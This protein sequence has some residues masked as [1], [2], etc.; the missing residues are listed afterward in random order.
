MSGLIHLQTFN[1]FWRAHKK[2]IRLLCVKRVILYVRR[3]TR[4]VGLIGFMK[5]EQKTWEIRSLKLENFWYKFFIKMCIKIWG[6]ESKKFKFLL[7]WLPQ[8]TDPSK[9]LRAFV[10]WGN[11]GP[12][13][14]PDVVVSGLLSK[15]ILSAPINLGFQFSVILLSAEA[16]IFGM[17]SKP[18]RAKIHKTHFQLFFSRKYNKG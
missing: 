5:V 6:M 10:R 3:W 16:F 1:A 2:R 12:T 14:S 15:R 18:N 7:L 9:R 8:E 17:C 13:K 11:M 4:C